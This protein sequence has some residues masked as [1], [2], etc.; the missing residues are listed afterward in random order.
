M[1]EAPTAAQLATAGWF[2]SSY[3][4]VNNECVEVAYTAPLVRIRD[5]KSLPQG[6][7]AIGT[8]A[9][10]LFVSSVKN[11]PYIRPQ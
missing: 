6:S 4:A 9:F 8:S 5:S 11:S 1:S 2:R 10:H 7:L 3:S